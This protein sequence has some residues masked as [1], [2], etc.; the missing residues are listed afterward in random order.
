MEL[1]EDEF[2]IC[3]YCGYIVG[4]HAEEAIHMEPGTI[5]HDRYIIGKVLGFGGFGVTYMGRQ[6]RAKSRHKRISPRRIFD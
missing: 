4:T 5:L 2:K 3:P 6:T 1:F